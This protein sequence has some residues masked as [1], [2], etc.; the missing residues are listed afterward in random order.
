MILFH[1]VAH[2]LRGLSDSMMIMMMIVTVKMMVA[3]LLRGFSDSMSTKK[4][5]AIA[6]PRKRR[7]RSLP[8]MLM[9]RLQRK[10]R[11]KKF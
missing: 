10:M 1:P 4:S 3:Y 2:L 7:T 8:S 5:E 11:K 6:E 9:M